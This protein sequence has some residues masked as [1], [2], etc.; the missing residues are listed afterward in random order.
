MRVNTAEQ[1]EFLL[2]KKVSINASKPSI[3]ARSAVKV[4]IK[5]KS[6]APQLSM[7]INMAF[8]KMDT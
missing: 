7:R 6:Q 2:T 1:S 3:E 5:T 4:R 8:R